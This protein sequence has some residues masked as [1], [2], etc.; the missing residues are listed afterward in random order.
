MK[1]Q[2]PSKIKLANLPT[3][4]KKMEKYS[5]TIDGPEIYIKRDDLT[6]ITLTGNK[7]RKLE[8][9]VAEALEQ[10]ADVLITCG[11]IQS[12]HARATAVVAAQ[13][14]INSFLVLRGQQT[15]DIDGNLFL[16]HLMG[17]DVKF[18]TA[19]DYRDH[20]DEIMEEAAENLRQQGYRPYIIPEGA[21][22]EL[23]AVGYIAATEE[24]VSQLK[25]MNLKIDTIISATGSGGTYAGLLMGKRIFNQNYEVYGIN[26]CDDEQYFINRI[27]EILKKAQNRFK[28]NLNLSRADIKIIDGYVGEGYALCRP[29]EIETIKKVAQTEAIVLD[30][31]Y[32]GKAMLGLTDQ[33]KKGRFI[34]GEK[35]LFLHSGGIFGLFAYR[36]LFG[37]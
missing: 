35:I 26:V 30:P 29:Q 32:T 37:K 33:I 6:G 5:Q 2:Y 21:S 27:S 16:D 13:S 14:G 18:I 23:G 4:I 15:A 24:I 20:V 9:V 11:G 31:V 36:G 12:N 25:A 28:L 1:F 22:N 8:F 7:V 3:P 10:N 34:K 17:A 19:E